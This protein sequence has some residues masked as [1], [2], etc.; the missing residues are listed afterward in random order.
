MP[1]GSQLA[2]LGTARHQVVEPA[3]QG[4]AS[5]IRAPSSSIFPSAESSLPTQ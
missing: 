5:S 2:L 1:P 4:R 3:D